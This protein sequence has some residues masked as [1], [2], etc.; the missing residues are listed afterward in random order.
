MAMSIGHKGKSLSQQ[1]INKLKEI[2]N[3]PA[4]IKLL[5]ER[6]SKIIFPLKDTSIEIKIQ[7]F[8]Q[9]LG[10]EYYT[11]KYMPE[12]NHAYQCDIFI[13]SMNMVIECDGN[14]WHK[15]PTGREI[16]NIRTKELLEKGFKVLRLWEHEINSMDVNNFKEQI[17]GGQE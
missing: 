5:K 15:Y 16:D 7:N 2:R 1:H 10:I 9:Q 14:Y 6:R 17:K 12:I 4:Y 13:P 11:H 3:K 8:L